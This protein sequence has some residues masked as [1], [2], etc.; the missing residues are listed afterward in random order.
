MNKLQLQ[1]DDFKEEIKRNNDK[2][3]TLQQ[4]IENQEDIIEA[5]NNSGNLL[6]ILFIE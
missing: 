1:C 5:L 6:L 4:K 2:I 3:S